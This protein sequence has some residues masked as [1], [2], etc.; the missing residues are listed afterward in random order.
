MELIHPNGARAILQLGWIEHYDKPVITMDDRV[1]GML[2]GPGE[3]SALAW[4]LEVAAQLE[5]AQFKQAADD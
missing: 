4:F 1:I 3:A 5:P 2:L